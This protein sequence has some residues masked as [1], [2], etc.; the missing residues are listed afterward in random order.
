MQE[1][2][3]HWFDCSCFTPEHSFRFTHDP[4]DNELYL[5]VHLTN[6]GFWNRLVQGIK[7]IFGHRS[8]YGEHASISIH[9]KDMDRLQDLLN[10]WKENAK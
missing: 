1:M 9:D 8:R 4:D 3:T 10:R 7:F 6:A 2:E 5:D